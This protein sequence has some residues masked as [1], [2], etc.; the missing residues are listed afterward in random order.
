MDLLHINLF[1]ETYKYIKAVDGS[2]GIKLQQ[3]IKEIITVNPYNIE[4]KLLN[5][6]KLNT[7]NSENK[8]DKEK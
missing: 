1:S 2:V 8:L 7:I 4:Y 6:E 5:N 3:Q